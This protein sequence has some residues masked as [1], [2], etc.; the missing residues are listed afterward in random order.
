MAN[1]TYQRLTRPAFNPPRYAIVINAFLFASISLSLAAAMMSVL[2]LQWVN[3]YDS[4]L[5]T[6]DIKKRALRRHWRFAGVEEWRMGGIIAALPVLLYISVFLFLVGI[7]VWTWT[8]HIIVGCIILTGCIL[9]LA[10]FVAT[11]LIAAIS[12]QAPFKSPMSRALRW[13]IESTKM[14]HGIRQ[15]PSAQ[16][17]N[18]VAAV[19]WAVK[20]MEIAENSYARLINAT[21]YFD[22]LELTI[23][24]D[25]STLQPHPL[26]LCQTLGAVTLHLTPVLE[27]LTLLRVCVKYFILRVDIPGSGECALMLKQSLDKIIE[28]EIEIRLLLQVARKT[29]PENYVSHEP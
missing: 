10:I 26:W 11:S 23:K 7:V 17:S 16:I 27:A 6:S 8:L 22:G 5:D 21:R 19:V 13:M 12:F 24:D 9:T 20:H 18:Q 2:A 14:L 29:V 1:G 4:K 28:T 25:L 3:E 15:D